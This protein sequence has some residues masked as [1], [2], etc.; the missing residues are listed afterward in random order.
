M[1]TVQSSPIPDY[2]LTMR[3]TL[4]AAVMVLGACSPPAAASRATTE[5]RRAPVAPARVAVVPAPTTAA[6]AWA[7]GTPQA[8][9]DLLLE[10]VERYHPDPFHGI[11]RAEFVAEV[12][13]L[14]DQMASLTGE[15]VA[16]EVM[17]LWGVLGSEGGDGHQLVMAVEEG[18]VLPIRLFQFADGVFVTDALDPDL[19]GARLV[20]VEGRPLDEVLPLVEA[21]V[22]GDSAATVPGFWPWFFLKADVL[23]GLGVITGSDAA[24]EL[25]LDRDGAIEN[26]VVDTVPLVDHI[27]WSGMFGLVHLPEGSGLHILDDGRRLWTDMPAPGALYRRY[28]EM[29]PVDP[30]EVIALRAAVAD[31]GVE[32]VIVDL[33]HNPGGNNHTYRSVR[34]IL[35]EVPQPLTV[36]IDRH[37]FSAA[38]NFATELE[39]GREVTFAGEDSGGAPNHWGDARFVRLE[40]LPIPLDVGIA[41]RYWRK[42]EPDDPRWWIEPDIEIPWVSTDYFTG[43]DAVL[44]AVLAQPG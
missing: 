28:R 8:D 37:T 6:A 27:A 30:A 25:T 14:Q 18:P 36:L 16:V 38:T 7:P 42:G 4:L 11:D 35:L 2:I 12:R 31:P 34:D 26:V 21:L 1:S 43:R 17:R 15:E 22:P 20:A 24:V 44:E 3:M 29:E 32:R 13:R 10:S 40:N 39:Q 41:T 19:R 9:L 23:E 5:T 33:R